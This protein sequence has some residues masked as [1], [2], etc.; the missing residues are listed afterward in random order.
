MSEFTQLPILQQNVRKMMQ[1][2]AP[3]DDIDGYLKSKGWTPE[4]FKAAN[5]GQQS[6]PQQAPGPY[7]PIDESPLPTPQATF[8]PR[9]FRVQPSEAATKAAAAGVISDK[10]APVGQWGLSFAY[11]MNSPSAQKYLSNE[12]TLDAN[13]GAP[14]IE[15]QHIAVR[16]GPKTGELEYYDPAS[17]RFALVNALGPDVGDFK[18]N[19]AMIGQMG[20][21]GAITT[22]AAA[23]TG[24]V[25][26]AAA[27]GAAAFATEA[28]RLAIGREMG[29]NEGMSDEDIAKA[30]G[31]AAGLTI[32]GGAA[33]SVAARSVKVIANFI[34]G[35]VFTPVHEAAYAGGQQAAKDIESQINKTGR[36]PP[37][38]YNLAQATGDQPLLN[39]AEMEYRTPGI[40][41]TEM[42]NARRQQQQA[43]GGFKQAIDQPQGAPTSRY[44]AG[45]QIQNELV[46]PQQQTQA[47]YGA[48]TQQADI[49]AQS[50]VGAL[51]Q[52]SPTVA[53]SRVTN[54]LLGEQ[55]AFKEWASQEAGKVD[56][57][58]SGLPIA[59]TNLSDT[60]KTFSQETR[61]AI[62]SGLQ[63][64]KKT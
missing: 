18:R 52:G 46:L 63:T 36:G 19:A 20:L 1:Q 2:N 10:A 31:I 27:G 56:A 32:A 55:D 12:L 6:Q 5:L 49:G 24:G 8:A 4:S 3:P 44:G 9:G 39:V 33:L 43:L 58:T 7:T 47:R 60:A 54:T 30:A 53:G 62:F 16:T 14:P 59:N 37:L 42:L 61:D 64:D 15:R 28:A 26:T 41:Q 21:E 23:F 57:A 22:G 48:Q 45:T 11:D 50:A 29:V 40:R 25:G 38:K 13:K 35:R 34:K 17:K 51:P